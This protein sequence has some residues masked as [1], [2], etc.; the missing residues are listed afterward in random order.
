MIYIIIILICGQP[1]LVIYHNK[2]QAQYIQY[3]KLIRS[4]SLVDQFILNL[5]SGVHF[6]IHDNRGQCA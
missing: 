5:N 3:E 4:Q 1:D 6:K 2:D